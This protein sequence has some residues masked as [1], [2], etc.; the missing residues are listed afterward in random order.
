MKILWHSNAPWNPSG[1]GSQTALFT[2]LIRDAGHEVAISAFWGLAGASLEWH[3]MK[4]YPGNGVTHAAELIPLYAF[5]QSGYTDPKDVQ[6]ITLID[7]WAITNSIL[8]E[9][10]VAAWTPIDHDPAPPRV[11]HFFTETGAVPIAMSRFGVDRLQAAGLD[12]LYVPHG[13]DTDVLCPMDKAEA[14]RRLGIPEDAFLVGMVAANNGSKPSRKGFPEAFEAFAEF[15][16]RHDDALLYVH[17]FSSADPS[18]RDG[19]NLLPLAELMGVPA[20]AIS[21]PDQMAMRIGIPYESM[22]VIYSAMDVLLNPAYGEGFGIPIVEA[23][24]CGVPVIV[25]DFTAMS[26]LA[27]PGWKVGGHPYFDSSNGAKWQL[28]SVPELVDALEDAYENAAEKRAA[29]REFALQYDVRRVMDEFWRPVL[30][31]L[32][33]PREVKPLLPGGPNRA[34]RRAAGRKKQAA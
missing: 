29:S 9:L 27:G 7:V 5:D 11:V 17:S 30:A 23:Q 28:P 12:P 6:V 15:R 16:N 33:R 2:P 21:F 3:G 20:G 24:A 10:R 31:E 18:G 34:Q 26:E 25:N 1:Y 22:H 4:V 32:D 14:R 13:I 19:L 8:K